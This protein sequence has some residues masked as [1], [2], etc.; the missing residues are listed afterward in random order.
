[1][2][3]NPF[4]RRGAN[5]HLLAVSMTG[6]KLGDRVAFVGVPDPG[7]VAAIA[8]K[9]GLSGRAAAAVPDADAVARVN[10][11]AADDGVLVDTDIADMK[12]LPYSDGEFDLAV[13]DDT[14]AL[15]EQLSDDDR[16][17]VAREAARILRPGGRVVVLGGGEPTGLN[18]LLAKSPASPLVLSG[19]IN[20]L[21]GANGFGIVRTLAEREGLVFVEGLR[22]RG[23][24][25]P[26]EHRPVEVLGPKRRQTCRQGF[27]LDYR[28]HMRTDGLSD[29]YSLNEVARAAGVSDAQARAAAGS[30]R[31]LSSRDAVR[32]G[33]ALVAERRAGTTA[34]A[35]PL[36]SRVTHAPSVSLRGL[37]LAVSGSLHVALLAT[38]IFSLGFFRASAATSLHDERR[39]A[40]APGV[41][42]HAGTRWR[43][44]RRR[45]PGEGAT[46]LRPNARAINPDRHAA[47]ASRATETR[48]TGSRSS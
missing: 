26:A 48:G 33:R 5:P 7:R 40:D 9:V 38:I 4:A 45:A 6:V 1:M 27:C 39:T 8:A 28:I 42:R 35:A 24:L 18:R 44:G 31:L 2:F 37:P 41:S 46:R 36:F 22:S 14:G 29:V 15:V 11:A 13:V 20:A 34:S 3:L 47:S 10:R 23:H 16:A 32:L 12:R 17:A 21:L 43:R 19:A 30:D 25:L